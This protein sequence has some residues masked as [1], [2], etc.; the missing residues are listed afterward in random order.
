MPE[1]NNSD[2]LRKQLIESLA[3]Q[4]NIDYKRILELSLQLSEF[5]K[6]NVRF[7]IDASHISRLG[8]ELVVKKETAVSELIKNAYDADATSVT[9]NFEDAELAGGLLVI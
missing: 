1:N 8:R 7:S 2:D 9:L 6:D 5:D 4:K 3:D